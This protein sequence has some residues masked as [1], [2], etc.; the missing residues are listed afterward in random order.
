MKRTILS[1]FLTLAF[2][3]LTGCSSKP[4]SKI[5][6][7]SSSKD[8][9]GAN[10]QQVVDGLQE[11]G[12]IN[13]K[14]EKM[15]DLI[16]GWL[17]KDGEVEKVEINGDTTF[18]T[19]SK[20]PKDAKIIVTYHTFKEKTDKKSEKSEQT[21]SSSTESSS[22]ITL[23]AKSNKDLAAV[24]STKNESDPII[25][26]FAE[27]YTGK[28]IE[29]DG[30]IAYINNHGTYKTRYDILIYA[31]DYS[32]TSATGPN[33]QFNDVGVNDLGIKGLYLPKFISTG[34]NIHV[35]AKVEKYDNNS[36]IFKLD[37]ISVKAR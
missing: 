35:I 23:T 27:E 32:K 2:V 20:Y 4:D 6:M 18:S 37:P 5:K 22:N 28:A 16:T 13:I 12:F 19:D 14:T 17:T 7:P 36:N 29:F 30:N 9:K 31:G 8:Y 11:A 10:Y 15:Q 24:L 1:L 3:M 21:Q 25:K 33:F 26:K 34:S